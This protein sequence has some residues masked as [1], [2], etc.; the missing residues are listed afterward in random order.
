[1][2]EKTALHEA[3]EE[4]NEAAVSSVLQTAGPALIDATTGALDW[5]ALHFAANQGHEGIVR[6]LL[7][8]RPHLIDKTFPD[9]WTPLHCALS[10]GH[11]S[12][13]ELLLARKP[14]LAFVTDAD[15]DTLLHTAALQPA[16]SAA[17]LVRLLKGNPG[18]L[19][20]LNEYGKTP[21]EIAIG[22]DNDVM[23]DV[24]QWHLTIDEIVHATSTI[25]KKMRKKLGCKR[26][27]QLR[28]VLEEQCC[29][30]LFTTLT[31]DVA[32]TVFVY[33]G[34]QTVKNTHIHVHSG[35]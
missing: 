28:L 4:G 21:I 20:V 27:E 9:G 2:A 5:T 6:Q 33:L 11:E 34:F 3:V 19:R 7:A 10:E 18:A 31:R 15:G 26:T 24:L 23:I 22:I 16:L 17:F 12:I 1:M 13:A 29:T 14:E 30:D 32:N 25:S 8:H 35:T